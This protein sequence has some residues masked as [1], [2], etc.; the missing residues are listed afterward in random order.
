MATFFQLFANPLQR[1]LL[2]A[3]LVLQTPV[4]GLDLVFSTA[5][6]RHQP[7]ILDGD[8]ALLGEIHD[9]G[10]GL[11]VENALAQTMVHVDRPH[12]VP[13]D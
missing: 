3:Q 6:L 9:H 11:V 1:L 10:Q 4:Q 2:D 5:K 8:G 13:L 7:R 12:H